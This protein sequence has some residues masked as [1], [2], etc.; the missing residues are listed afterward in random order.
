M[1]T[2]VHKPDASKPDFRGEHDGESKS[3]GAGIRP[4]V[5]SRLAVARERIRG[6]K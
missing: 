4:G 5:K 3:A 6:K 2:K 1:G